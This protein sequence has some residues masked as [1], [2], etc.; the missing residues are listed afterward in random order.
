MIISK[1]NNATW[2]TR[3]I[4]PPLSPRIFLHLAVHSATVAIVRAVHRGP[5]PERS[6]EGGSSLHGPIP[7]MHRTQRAPFDEKHAHKD[8]HDS[9]GRNYGL[10]RLVGNFDGNHPFVL[11]E[12]PSRAH[13]VSTREALYYESSAPPPILLG[14]FY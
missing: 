6:G 7:A 8:G 14:K 13:V 11:Y 10:N 4:F 1:S 12:R 2:R 3:S 5:P 9:R